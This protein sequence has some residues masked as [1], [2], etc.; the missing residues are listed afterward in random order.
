MAGIEGCLNRE[1]FW[2]DTKWFR[3]ACVRV[4]SFS[5]NPR[6]QWWLWSH[7]NRP[8]FVKTAC[9]IPTDRE[10][11]HNVS[12]RGSALEMKVS[13]CGSF[14]ALMSWMDRGKSARHKKGLEGAD[15]SAKGKEKESKGPRLR[16]RRG[17]YLI[18]PARYHQSPQ[19][20][21]VTSIRDSGLHHRDEPLTREDGGQSERL[22][23]GSATR[24]FCSEEKAE[25]LGQGTIYQGQSPP[26]AW[27]TLVECV[28]SSW[29]SLSKSSDI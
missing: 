12:V 27:Q 13:G 2:H 7:K 18:I 3:F 11:W 1:T 19:T 16:H 29:L 8:R 26:Q 15:G 17:V 14:D 5:F 23:G 28:I 24:I 20:W 4:T 21:L 9:E 25:L 6:G 22:T 10:V